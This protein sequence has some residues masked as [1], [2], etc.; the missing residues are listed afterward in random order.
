MKEITVETADGRK[1]YT[2]SLSRLRELALEG[3]TVFGP[4]HIAGPMTTTL[5]GELIDTQ[6]NFTVALDVF[7]DLAGLWEGV[8]VCPRC[9]ARVPQ[10]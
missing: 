2:V 9:A 1:E 10:R 3:T 5:C 4:V 8:P 6:R 7:Q